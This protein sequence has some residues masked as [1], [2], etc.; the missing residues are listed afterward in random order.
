MFKHVNLL[1]YFSNNLAQ[2][3]VTVVVPLDELV[4]VLAPESLMLHSLSVDQ[5]AHQLTR[6]T[7]T[8]APSSNKTVCIRYCQLPD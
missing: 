8:A 3:Q 4:V 5:S 7:N 2:V 1:T 6:Y